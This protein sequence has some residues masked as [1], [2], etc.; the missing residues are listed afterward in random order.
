MGSPHLEYSHHLRSFLSADDNDFIRLLPVR[1]FFSTF[2]T[3][4]LP[5]T[6]SALASGSL[7]HPSTLVGCSGGSVVAGNPLRKLFHTKEKASQQTWFSHEWVPGREKDGPGASKFYDGF[8]IENLSLLR[9]L[10]GDKRLMDG[11]ATVTIFEERTGV[12]ALAWNPNRQCA[13]WASA[14]L[15]CGLIRMENLAI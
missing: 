10:M 12:T 6:I 14:G 9:N 15:G 13:G 11:T 4:K 7:W 8:R 5:S 3:I 1:R 2:A